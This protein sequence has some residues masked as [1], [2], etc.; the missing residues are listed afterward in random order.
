MGSRQK[1]I[2]VSNPVDIRIK[3]SALWIVT[4]FVFAYV[5]L[6]DFYRMDVLEEHYRLYH[7]YSNFCTFVYW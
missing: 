3:I 1:A 5:D 6:F 7:L 2:F 4:M